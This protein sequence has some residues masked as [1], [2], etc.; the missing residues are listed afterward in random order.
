MEV[1]VTEPVDPNNDIAEKEDLES[2]PKPQQVEVSPIFLAK[3]FY[4]RLKTV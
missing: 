3:Q 4:I 2:D 1:T